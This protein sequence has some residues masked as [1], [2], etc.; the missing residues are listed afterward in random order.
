[1]PVMHLIVVCSL[2]SFRSII[3][4]IA[5]LTVTKLAK[6]IHRLAS[7]YGSVSIPFLLFTLPFSF[8]QQT[9][10]AIHPLRDLLTRYPHD[11]TFLTTIHPIFMLVRIFLQFLK[12]F[13]LNAS[14]R[15]VSQPATFLL[16]CLF[17]PVRLPISIPRSLPSCTIAIIYRTIT[18][19]VS[20]WLL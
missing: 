5:T 19:E 9:N 13:K 18:L 14:T 3:R 20:R 16:L 1:M 15:H 4:L 12:I 7:H 11:T 8:I 10:L 2:R 6:G 17:F